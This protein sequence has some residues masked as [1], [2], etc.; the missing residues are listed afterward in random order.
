MQLDI[1]SSNPRVV[2][3]LS[4]LPTLQ[5][6]GPGATPGT[7]MHTWPEAGLPFHWKVPCGLAPRQRP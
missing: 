2:G 4:L 1:V 6:P 7:S 3:G 5:L